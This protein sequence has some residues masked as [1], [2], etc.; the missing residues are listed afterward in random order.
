MSRSATSFASRAARVIAAVS[1]AV[2]LTSSFADAR[3]GG[4]GSFGSRGSR[5]STSVPSTPTA[6]R[7]ATPLPGAPQ[8]APGFRPSAPIAAPARSGF[9]SLLMG[10]LLGAGLFGLLSGSGLFGGLG[11][12]ASMFGLLLQG[13]L[14][15]FVV[16][17][18]LN[19]FR[20][21]NQ[22]AM[23]GAQG[24]QPG[25]APMGAPLQGGAYSGPAPLQ[26]SPLTIAPEDF[27][28]FEKRLAE[29]QGAYSREDTSALNALTTPD[30]AAH[31]AEELAGH[32]AQ[33]QHNQLGAPKLLQGDL[34]ESWRENGRDFATVAMR[35]AMTDAM[36]D[37]TTGRVVSGDAATPGEITEVWTFVRNS[38]DTQGWKLSAI[39]Q[40]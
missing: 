3:S 27:G 2:L 12:I 6:P 11:G 4:G 1:V 40:A 22:P 28:V 35:Y 32:K 15:F 17:L 25:S 24:F 18:A 19:F 39:Q 29:I 33:G 9:G 14:L 10:G 26:T 5:S 8:A 37:R 20:S 23:A 21:R 16:K 7:A 34:A 36:V 31:M 38:G 13:V 30:I